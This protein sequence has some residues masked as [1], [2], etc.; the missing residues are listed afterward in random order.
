VSYDVYLEIDTGAEC[1]ATVADIGNYTANVS[2]MWTRALGEPLAD[3][4]G[5]TAGG[6]VE[7][8]DRAIAAMQAAPGE[9]E[10]MNPA[11]G[12]G[13]FEGALNYLRDLRAACAEHPKTQIRVSH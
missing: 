6:V 8:L 5:R 11:N 12:W 10:A 9:Y 7:Q 3:L 1:M 13:R 4:H 2:P